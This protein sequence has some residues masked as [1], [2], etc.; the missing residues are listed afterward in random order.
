MTKG[1]VKQ[2]CV[3]VSRH[4]PAHGDGGA[5]G[6]RPGRERCPQQWSTCQHLF[7]HPGTEQCGE[8]VNGTRAVTRE[9][10]GSVLKTDSS[11]LCKEFHPLNLAF[12]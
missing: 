7:F 2:C 9:R 12:E 5:C 10:E 4:S 3:N 11:G 6:R 1:V 8:A